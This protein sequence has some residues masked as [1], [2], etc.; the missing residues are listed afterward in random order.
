MY[1][2]YIELLNLYYNDLIERKKMQLNICSFCISSM[3]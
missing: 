1:G 3:S 2:I